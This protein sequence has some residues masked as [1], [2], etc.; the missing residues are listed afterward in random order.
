MSRL[1]F[2]SSACESTSFLSYRRCSRLAFLRRRWL[3]RPLIRVIL[4]EPVTSKRFCAPLC[5]LSLYFLGIEVSSPLRYIYLAGIIAQIPP[6]REP[7]PYAI[8]AAVAG[9][10][11]VDRKG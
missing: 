2:A 1:I 8:I 5:V 3:F 10:S 9:I 4:P 6:A 11:R 7:R